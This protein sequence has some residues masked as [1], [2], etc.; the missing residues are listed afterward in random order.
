MILKHEGISHD[1]IRKRSQ[2]RVSQYTGS[3]VRMFQLHS[4]KGMETSV[5]G[6]VNEQESGARDQGGAKAR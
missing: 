5:A 2:Q 3:L 1:S 4:E 6:T